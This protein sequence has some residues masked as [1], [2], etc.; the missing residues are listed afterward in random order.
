MEKTLQAIFDAIT[1][2][3][4]AEVSALVQQALEEN[5]DPKTIL[6]QSMVAAMREVGDLFES[7]EKFV[8][9]ML[10]SAQTM[11]NGLAVLKP[12]LIA[13][14]VKAVGKVVIG[15]VK[16]DL[17]DIGKNLVGLMLEGAGFEVID[18]GTDVAPQQFVHAAEEN[19]ADI[20]A[21]SALLTTTLP[22]METTVKELEQA[23]LHTKVGVFVGGA[24]VTED[25]AKAI[26]ADGYAIDA[27]RAVRVMSE[28]LSQARG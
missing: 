8:P 23:R 14:N 4:T 24:P 26:G 7:G 1:Q 17:H 21:L 3:K 28:W 22:N 2:G 27:S 19:Q 9:E 11:Q 12:S 16:G 13:D 5:L 6:D 15:T 20:V 18:L 25:H 10:I